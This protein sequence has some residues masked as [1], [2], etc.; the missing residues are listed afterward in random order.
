MQ[1]DGT[2]ISYS[3]KDRGGYIDAED[4][5]E[6]FYHLSDLPLG[7][8]HPTIGERVQFV[9]STEG[10][11]HATQIERLDV[12]VP[13]GRWIK[14]KAFKHQILQRYHDQPVKKQRFI[15]IGVLVSVLLVLSLMMFGLVNLYQSH[16]LKKA[17]Q[18]Q[19]EQQQAIEKQKLAL[20]EIEF[21]GLSENARR[22]IDGKVY[23]TVKERT[24]V[25]TAGI[26]K[27][28]GLLP[29]SIAK[30]KCDQRTQCY[31]MR[32]YDEALYFHRHCRKAKLDSNGNG[33]PCEN[34]FSK[35]K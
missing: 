29:V 34:E 10:F 3:A 4:F 21:D 16:Q 8:I 22:N 24:E 32:S 33:I 28:N 2:I 12:V 19:I 1:L 26:D 6:I 13:E 23:G 15:L 17:Q 7:Y 30:F 31:Q 11:L 9:L 14:F 35:L 20:G 25:V 27:R 5:P 18:F